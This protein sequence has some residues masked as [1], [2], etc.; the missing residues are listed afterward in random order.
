MAF[1]EQNGKV[2]M[3][4]KNKAKNS[5][6]EKNSKDWQHGKV[7]VPSRSLEI[8]SFEIF[9]RISDQFVSHAIFRSGNEMRPTGTADWGILSSD[10]N[11]CDGSMAAQMDRRLW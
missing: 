7:L 11:D 2:N 3:R 10:V 1:K 5:V 4:V 6:Q 8:P 9:K